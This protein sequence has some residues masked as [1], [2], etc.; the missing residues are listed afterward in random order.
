MRFRVLGSGS[1]GNT[2]LVEAGGT[3]LLIDAGLGPREMA[4]RLQ[5]LGID[6]ASIAAI[7]LTHEHS[8][9]SRGAAS[10]SNKWGVR[11]LGSRGTYAAGGFGA[12]DIAG[13]DVLEPG[14]RARLRRGHRDGGAHSRT[15][16][17]DRWPSCSPATASRWATPPTSVT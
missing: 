15:T 9:H 17:R 10:F 2:T 12:V 5:S 16:P 1:S 4:E 8:D 3:F 6:P 13:W 7:L 14:R 11:V